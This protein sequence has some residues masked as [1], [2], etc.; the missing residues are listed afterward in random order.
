[1]SYVAEAVN[2][3]RSQGRAIAY[4]NVRYGICSLLSSCPALGRASTSHV[5]PARKT[6]VAGTS[7]AMTMPKKRL[8]SGHSSYAIALG[9]RGCRVTGAPS[10]R[11]ASSLGLPM[12]ERRIEKLWPRRL[13]CEGHIH[14][15]SSKKK[16][17]SI[18][19]GLGIGHLRPTQS[20]SKRD[21]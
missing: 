17:G 15:V 3:L 8:R 4:E 20:P 18:E 11:F 1:M 16:P 2:G 19:P 10:P 6:R 12:R 13:I 14:H 21:D 7:P 9:H 5:V